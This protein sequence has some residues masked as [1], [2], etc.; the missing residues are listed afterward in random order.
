[1]TLPAP[2]SLS[3]SEIVRY[4]ADTAYAA[5]SARTAMHQCADAFDQLPALQRSASP[6]TCATCQHFGLT[7]SRLGCCNSTD[8]VG[9][10]GVSV[11]MHVRKPELFGCLY[12]TPQPETIP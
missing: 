10:G 6:P 4:Q 1:M 8:V 12:H 3:P 5:H 9:V 7:P 2:R 11:I